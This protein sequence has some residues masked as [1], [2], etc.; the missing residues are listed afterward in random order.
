MADNSSLRE[1]QCGYPPNA[2]A[3]AWLVIIWDALRLAG[4]ALWHIGSSSSC[5]PPACGFRR[6]RLNVPRLSEIRERRVGAITRAER[7][8]DQ[9]WS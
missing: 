7:H 2:N 6:L 5:V 9:M 4:R 8:Y 1:F 3:A